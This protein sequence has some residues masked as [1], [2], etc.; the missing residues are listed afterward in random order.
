MATLAACRSN[1]SE[2]SPLPPNIIFLMADDLGYGEL[3]SYGNDSIRT[4]HLD[5][6]A[7]EG[8][9]FTDYHTN[10]AVCTPTRAALLTG[11]YQQ[12][13]GLEG[14]I[15]VRGETRQTGLN[16]ETL[17]L[18]DVFQGAGYAT[19][20]MGKWHLGYQAAY[21]PIHFGF[22]E[23]WGYISGNIDY[24]SHYDNA[25]IYDWYHNLD[26][27]IEEGYSTDLIT[28]HAVDFIEQHQT[29]P[30]FLYVPQESP[31]VPFQARRDSAY[32]F[33]GREFSYQGPIGDRKRA[34]REMIEQ[35]DEGIGKIL[36]KVE[37]LNLAERTL[38]IFTS[39]NG[40][41]NSYARQGGLRNFKGYLWEGGHRVPAIAHWPGRISPGQ[42]DQ[43]TMSF[44]WFPTLLHMADISLP[45]GFS[46]DGINL[47]PMLFG[48]R[49]PNRQVFWRYRDQ[50]AAR[51]ANWKLMLTKTDTLLFDL[52][53]D[54]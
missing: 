25:G 51:E 10:G 1:D 49:L 9:V 28:Q 22:D 20:I 3:G 46:P 4:P 35:M 13:S 24:H 48:A 30:F 15:Y 43:L 18:A 29:D 34:Y 19:G 23:F 6:M 44:D 21:N 16:P 2:K 47:T 26:T 53:S 36:A 11:Q 39:D 45:E 14:V 40:G 12:R 8:L 41:I 17:T 42:T 5:R 52:A 7:R 50:L 31:H 54:L 37:A 27:V 32:R 33:P 38:I